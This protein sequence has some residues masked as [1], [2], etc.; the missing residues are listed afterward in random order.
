V[1]G[2]H[3]A[4]LPLNHELTRRGARFLREAATAPA[5]RLHALAGGPPARPGLV[6]VSEGGA[7]IALEVWALPDEAVGDFLAGVPAPLSIGTIRLAHGGAVK[8]F[9]CESAGLGGAVDVTAHGGWRAY[10]AAGGP[11]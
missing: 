2:A 1:V 6:R 11:K 7:S 4:G 5:Y 3:M 8:G 10:L 9:L